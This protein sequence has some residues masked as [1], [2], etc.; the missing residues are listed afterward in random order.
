MNVMVIHHFFVKDFNPEMIK[1]HLEY[2]KEL[3]SNGHLVTVKS[4]GP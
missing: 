1:G 2:L 3:N 4:T